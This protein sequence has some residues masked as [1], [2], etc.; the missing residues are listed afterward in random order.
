MLANGNTQFMIELAKELKFS[1]TLPT[2]ALQMAA[3]FFH[4]R[5]YINYDRFIILT[6]CLLLAAKLKDM[7]LRVKNIC[8]A[9]Y[10]TINN[11]SQSHEPYD[12][13]KLRKIR[14]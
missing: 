11:R 10:T 12:E 4:I 8:Y 2:I 7:D 1:Y 13:E 5:C 9:F 6:A 3:K 14:D